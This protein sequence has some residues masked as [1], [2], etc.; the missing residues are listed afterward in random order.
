MFCLK[1]RAS[2]EMVLF[3]PQRKLALAVSLLWLPD[4][5]QGQILR[6]NPLVT[7]ISST[8]SMFID[9][10]FKWIRAFPVGQTSSET[11]KTT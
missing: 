7:V 8:V 10:N 11:I 4:I 9:C 1:S 6:G 2:C 3:A 5:M